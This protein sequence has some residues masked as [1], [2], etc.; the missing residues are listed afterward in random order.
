[1]QARLFWWKIICIFKE[2]KLFITNIYVMNITD[3]GSLPL[4]FSLFLRKL[5]FYIEFSFIIEA[6][7]IEQNKITNHPLVF[8]QD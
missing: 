7:L 2:K 5:Y 6:Y 8:T 3:T 1:M 4:I